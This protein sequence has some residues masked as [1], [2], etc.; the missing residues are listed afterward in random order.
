MFKLF[1][2]TPAQAKKT[3]DEFT[4][5]NLKKLHQCIYKTMHNS[6]KKQKNKEHKFL[7]YRQKISPAGNPVHKYKDSTGRY[8]WFDPII[9]L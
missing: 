2:I 8:I 7:I 4:Q 9:Q 1:Y 3:L 6:Y 5:T